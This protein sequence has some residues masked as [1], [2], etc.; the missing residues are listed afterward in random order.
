MNLRGD[1]MEYIALNEMMTYYHW[2][3][4][5]YYILVSI[6]F[7]NC[8]KS[9]IYFTSV[10]KDKSL[11][12]SPSYIDIFISILANIGLLCGTLFQGILTDIPANNGSQWW[13]EYLF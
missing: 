12:S 11:E 8:M 2:D 13:S 9:L 7:I 10:K 6:V 4:F 5:V 1:N 3:F